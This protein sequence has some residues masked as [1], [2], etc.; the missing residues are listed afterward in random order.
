M[1][2]QRTAIPTI[3]TAML[4]AVVPATAQTGTYKSLWPYPISNGSSGINYLSLLSQ[5][6]DGNLYSTMEPF[7][8]G[9]TYG[10]VYRMTTL[11]GYSLLFGFCKEGNPC[12]TTGSTPM[13]GVTLGFDG[14][15]W[16]TTEYGE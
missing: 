15:L 7:L 16:G 14:N 6:R 5:G 13:G 9:E 4:F 2:H 8:N 1:K 12:A 11:G 3:A 10:S